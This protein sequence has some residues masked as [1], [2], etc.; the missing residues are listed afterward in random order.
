MTGGYFVEERETFD[1]FV[2]RTAFET[3]YNSANPATLGVDVDDTPGQGLAD[4]F[5]LRYAGAVFRP[6]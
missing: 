3:I 1:F 6:T 4:D 5:V 2:E